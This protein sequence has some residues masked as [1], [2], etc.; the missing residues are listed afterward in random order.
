MLH[1]VTCLFTTGSATG[2]RRVGSREGVGGEKRKT[3]TEGTGVSRHFQEGHCGELK[4]LKITRHLQPTAF[5]FF[6]LPLTSLLGTLKE[7]QGGYEGAAW[8]LQC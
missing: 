2:K 3:L 5:F 7:P 1:K 8:L 6:A 4:P